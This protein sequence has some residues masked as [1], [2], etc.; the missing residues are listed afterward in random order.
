[1][2]NSTLCSNYRGKANTKLISFQT[3]DLIVN[4]YTETEGSPSVYSVTFLKCIGSSH[5]QGYTKSQVEQDRVGK[6]IF[7]YIPNG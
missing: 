4:I 1:M 3:F 6:N 5:L 2:F 7:D